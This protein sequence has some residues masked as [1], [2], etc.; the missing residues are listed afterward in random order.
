[1]AD[2]NGSYR[3]GRL[4]AG[5]LSGGVLVMIWSAVWYEALQTGRAAVAGWQTT[6]SQIG[7]FGGAAVAAAALV[8]L[9]ACRPSVQNGQQATARQP[10]DQAKP[11]VRRQL[12][13]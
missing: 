5:V 2:T 9:R 3:S 1:M 8:Y 12:Q 6:A 11:K 7:F 10:A 13:L 4:A